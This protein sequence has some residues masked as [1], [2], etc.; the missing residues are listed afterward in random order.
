MMN[1]DNNIVDDLI[2]LKQRSLYYY[3]LLDYYSDKMNEITCE[4]EELTEEL[5]NVKK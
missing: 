5:N 2:L 4:I 3:H 1:I